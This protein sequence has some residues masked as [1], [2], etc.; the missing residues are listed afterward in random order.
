[1]SPTAGLTWRNA[2]QRAE[3][4]HE[5]RCR[6][7]TWQEIADALGYGSRMSAEKAR[8]L[9]LR[10]HPADPIAVTRRETAD[11]LA[12][13]AARII[14]AVDA[15]PANKAA[16]V[17][18]AVNAAKSAAEVLEKRAKVL[19]L[20]VPVQASVDVT[21]H[22]SPTAVLERAEAELL[23]LCAPEDPN[24]IDAEVVEE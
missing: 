20:H 10:R 15:L 4:A 11:G 8:S 23:A 12:A 7:W 16:T 17:F 21:V 13:L 9:W 6:G 3:Q 1:M 22:A 19:G 2:D 5:L 14:E 24:I 18:A